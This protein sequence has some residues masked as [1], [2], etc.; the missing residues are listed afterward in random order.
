MKI[1]VLNQ[2]QGPR[3]PL[4]SSKG[5]KE[6]YKNTAE[7]K[8]Y[9]DPLQ[10]RMPWGTGSGF[11]TFFASCLTQHLLSD[12]SKLSPTAPGSMTGC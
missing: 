5:S 6:E 3:I 12:P 1:I 7:Y 2:T 8:E 9:G 10:L 4:I 11:K